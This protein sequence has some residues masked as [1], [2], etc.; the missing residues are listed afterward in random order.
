MDKNKMVLMKETEIDELIGYLKDLYETY[1]LTHNRAKFKFERLNKLFHN[2]P[3]RWILKEYDM[4][5]RE[6][7]FAEMQSLSPLIRSL[8]NKLEDMGVQV[9]D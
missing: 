5:D 2:P 9:D 4:R 7:A 3:K 6:S 8:K 1:K